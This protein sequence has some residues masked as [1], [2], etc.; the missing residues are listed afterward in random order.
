M[1][2][3]LTSLFCFFFFFFNG[4]AAHR[5]YTKAFRGKGRW[6]KEA[7]PEP[8]GCLPTGVGRP[9]VGKPD[10][11]G[12]TPILAA[13]EFQDM[14]YAACVMPVTATHVIV[15]ALKAYYGDLLENGDLREAM[16]HGIGFAAYTELVGLPQQ[17][18]SEQAYLDAARALAG[19]A[20]A[21]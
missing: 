12:A 13:V 5:V 21:P 7:D 4:T 8:V 10:D 3:S 17:R 20:G 15:K 18:A 9:F 6:F 14:G 1:Q 11:G 16:H 19:T 2:M